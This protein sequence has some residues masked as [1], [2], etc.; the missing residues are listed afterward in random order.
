MEAGSHGGGDM[1]LAKA[2]VASVAGNDQSQLGVTPREIL[3]S[4]LLVFAA[5]TAR[6]EGRVVDFA[7]FEKGCE[8]GRYVGS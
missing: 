7:E 1:G 5:E 3:D 4:H 8:E 2:F 6:R